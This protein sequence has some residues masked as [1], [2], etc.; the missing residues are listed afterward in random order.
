MVVAV[1][2]ARYASTR[3]PG[4][5]LA[6]IA[7]QTMIERVWRATSNA[8]LVDRV[9][10]ATESRLV[11]AEAVRL[12]A[13]V[14]MTSDQLPSGT[15]RCAAAIDALGLSPEI[16][17]NVQ[18]DEPLLQPEILTALVKA[19]RGSSADVTTPV[20]EVTV[21]SDLTDSNYVTVACTA[22]MRALYFSRSA[23]PNVR[24][25]EIGDWLKHARYWKHVGLYCYRTS[26]LQKHV[27]LPATKLELAEQLEQLRLL[28]AGVQFRCVPITQHLIAVDVPADV[29]KVELE[30]LRSV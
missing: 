9:V 23:I 10:I 7:G 3:F 6:V 28:E 24:G 12:G 14:V 15:D 21:V 2:P 25:V 1:I 17:L 30:L 19:L 27:Q 20:V 29:A 5:P 22:D 18:G 11:E 16:V 4:K 13:E 8:E 26:A